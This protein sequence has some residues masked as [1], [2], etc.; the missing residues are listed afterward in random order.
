MKFYI[1]LISAW[2]YIAVSAGYLSLQRSLDDISTHN[3]SHQSGDPIYPNAAVYKDSNNP[4]VLPFSLLAVIESRY[5]I[6][7]VHALYHEFLQK[8]P[9]RPYVAVIA[10]ELPR[11]NFTMESN[12]EHIG[13]DAIIPSS[14][15]KDFLN[16]LKL[17][18]HVSVDLS[19]LQYPGTLSAEINHHLFHY[20]KKMTSL[21][22][23]IITVGSSVTAIAAGAVAELFRIPV[24]QLATARSYPSSH[25]SNMHSL[26]SQRLAERISEL[27]S[28]FIMDVAR[29]KVDNNYLDP[30]E[31]RHKAR[32]VGSLLLDA[33]SRGLSLNTKQLMH[34]QS[35]LQATRVSE[36]FRDTS[37]SH[38][39]QEPRKY[40]VVGCS[41]SC[42]NMIDKSSFASYI[43]T[44]KDLASVHSDKIVY[45]LLDEEKPEYTFYHT[46]YSIY[47]SGM[48][49]RF[50]SMQSRMRSIS[51]VVVVDV[52]SDY[53]VYINF[54]LSAEMYIADCDMSDGFI[55]EE[56]ISLDVRG[57]L[58]R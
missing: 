16:S 6:L 54:I 48:G 30:F 27:H 32:V 49:D 40:I 12:V 14:R 55:E 7:R 20:M 43:Q 41:F 5:D 42:S 8:F 28:V 13:H 35:L 9:K 52:L 56:I 36:S 1:L 23:M 4:H 37:R 3:A 21:P 24:L 11:K 31:R 50:N 29:Y 18:E 10:I 45:I 17:K 46:N 51:N 26:N 58:I 33:I 47:G 38:G 2:C 25:V 15:L 53:P 57:I 34:F 19:Y 44:M 39:F 22:N